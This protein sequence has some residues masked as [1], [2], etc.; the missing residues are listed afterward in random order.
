LGQGREKKF[1]IPANATN[2]GG[3]VGQVSEQ[4]GIGKAP[5]NDD[6][7][8]PRVLLILLRIELSTQK[9]HPAQGNFV[10]VGGR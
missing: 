4:L 2:Q 10:D 6:S 8:V 7:Q 1:R 5:V 3:V 9:V